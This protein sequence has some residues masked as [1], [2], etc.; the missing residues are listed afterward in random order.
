MSWPKTSQYSTKKLGIMKYFPISTSQS[1][2][3]GQQY[4]K[5]I[6]LELNV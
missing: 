1:A 6:L 5:T 3:L 2:Q 4:R